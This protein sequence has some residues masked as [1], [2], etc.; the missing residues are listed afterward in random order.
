MR[1]RWGRRTAANG[2]DARAAALLVAALLAWGCGDP[3]APPTMTA[4]GFEIARGRDVRIGEPS[5]LR[6]RV[7]APAGLESLRIRER[8]YDVD[9]A[10][11][12]EASHFPLF[13]L[14]RRVWSKTDVTL[15]FGP[16]LQRKITEPGRYA[17]DILVTDRNEAKVTTRLEVNV[18]PVEVR[19]PGVEAEQGAGTTPR[20]PPEA[21]RDAPVQPDADLGS[22]LRSGDFRLERVGRGPVVSGD[23]FGIEWKTVESTHVVIRI[24]AAEGE[25]GRFVRLEP[26]A[27]ESVESRAQLADMIARVSTQP[28]IELT[29]ANDSAA[30][31]ELA[32][33]GSA[34]SL[35]LR[36]DHSETRLSDE[37]T[38]VTLSGRYKR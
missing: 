5:S 11:S 15:D 7:E 31:T 29:T 28:T 17:F 33:V 12:P 27:F 21:S 34:A 1:R 4:Q 3:P 30:G 19:E 26:G 9:L 20:P 38:T 10:Q 37:G 8:S 24:A 22:S 25:G 35:L 14:P 2:R 18:L 32:V 6:L 23:E 16:Y 36:T 13:G